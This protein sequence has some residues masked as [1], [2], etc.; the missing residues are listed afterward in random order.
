MVNP[1]VVGA[2]QCMQQLL[3][4][5]A[6]ALASVLPVPSISRMGQSS[7]FLGKGG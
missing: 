3:Y 4:I 5:L 6:C 2:N 1:S 7:M